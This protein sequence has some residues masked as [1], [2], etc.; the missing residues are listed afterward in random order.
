MS[1]PPREEN[2]RT[3]HAVSAEHVGMRART[4]WFMAGT[5]VAVGPREGAA[6][7]E[8]PTRIHLRDDDG[9]VHDFLCDGDFM[10]VWADGGDA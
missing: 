2:G 3:A 5:I 4:W 8:P 1:R 10:A 6:P 9:E 7:G